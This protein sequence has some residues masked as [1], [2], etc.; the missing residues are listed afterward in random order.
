[1]VCL[2]LDDQFDVTLFP[3]LPELAF[4]VAPVCVWS[5]HSLLDPGRRE[6]ERERETG[7]VLRDWFKVIQAKG[8]L[9]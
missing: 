6:R 7:I 3:L 8:D 4:S 9:Q 2:Y 5:H 1:M